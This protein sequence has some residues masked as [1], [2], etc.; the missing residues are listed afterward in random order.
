MSQKVRDTKVG[1][2][3]AAA[4]RLL[5]SKQLEDTTKL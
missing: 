2:G 5:P 1:D 4:S 3:A